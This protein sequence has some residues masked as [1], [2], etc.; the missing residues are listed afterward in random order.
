[1]TYMALLIGRE[2][3]SVS[4]QTPDFINFQLFLSSG[5]GSVLPLVFGVHGKTAS[6]SRSRDYF[7]DFP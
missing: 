4:F 2:S 6:E 1:M 7:E 5:G 3:K